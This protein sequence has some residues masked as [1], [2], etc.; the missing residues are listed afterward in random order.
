[1]ENN[2][3]YTLNIETKFYPFLTEKDFELRQMLMRRQNEIGLEVARSLG[4]YLVH[5]LNSKHD[6]Q[7]KEAIINTEKQA[8]DL[9]LKGADLTVWAD[10]FI[11]GRDEYSFGKPK[12]SALDVI[13]PEFTRLKMILLSAGAEYFEQNC[14]GLFNYDRSELLK[15]RINNG[16][17]NI[18]N[19]FGDKTLLQIA[20]ERQQLNYITMLCQLGANP[21]YRSEYET[22]RP[23]ALEMANSKL[24]YYIQKNIS[25]SEI[26]EIKKIIELLNKYEKDWKQAEKF[27]PEE[28]ADKS[29]ICTVVYKSNSQLKFSDVNHITYT[30]ESIDKIIER[31]NAKAA[32][33]KKENEEYGL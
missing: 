22:N 31:N 1:M 33:I 17:Y 9:I 8:I 27:I 7:N 30:V 3:E 19:K 21:F 6:G 24:E 23:T 28:Y 12:L 15:E 25:G 4:K 14:K 13:G 26:I 2:K 5:L 16:I 29:L 18:D 11:Y 10:D 32:A 20:T